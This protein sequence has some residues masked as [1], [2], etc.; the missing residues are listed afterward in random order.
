MEGTSRTSGTCFTPCAYN[1]SA[2]SFVLSSVY[3]PLFFTSC[4]I[5]DVPNVLD[6]PFFEVELGVVSG[7]TPESASSDVPDVPASVCFARNGK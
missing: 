5:V 6:V 1:N 2:L 3:V 4:C 7:F